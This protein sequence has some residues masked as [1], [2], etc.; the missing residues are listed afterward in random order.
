MGPGVEA[1]IWRLSSEEV[2]Q[3]TIFEVGRIQEKKMFQG[4]GKDLMCLLLESSRDMPFGFDSLEIIS[5][6]DK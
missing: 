2:S 6:P 1:C 5:Y 3:G 4:E